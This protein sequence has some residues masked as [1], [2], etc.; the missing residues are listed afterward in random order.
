[1]VRLTSYSVLLQVAVALVALGI[2]ALSSPSASAASVGSDPEELTRVGNVL[3]FSAQGAGGRELWKSDGTDAGTVRVKDIR[4]GSGSSNP[5]ALTD[6]DGTLF[7]MAFDGTDG[8]LWASDGTEAGTK[9]VKNVIGSEFTAVGDKLFFAIANELWSSDGTGAGTAAIRTFGGDKYIGELE[10]VGDRLFV[11]VLENTTD[12]LWVSDGSAEGTRLVEKVDHVEQATGI[13]TMTAV[14]DRLFFLRETE[15][16]FDCGCTFP[17]DLWTSDGTS[18]G[19]H[20]V[21]DLRTGHDDVQNLVGAKGILYLQEGFNNLWR[22]DGTKAGTTK[23]K[24]FDLLDPAYPMTNVAGKV[25]LVADGAL[26]KSNGT[27]NGTKLVD[28]VLPFQQRRCGPFGPCHLIFH[29][30]DPV[31]S[32]GVL[33]FPSATGGDGVELWR[34]D[35]TAQGTYEVKDIQSG[36][37]GS[38]PADL[39]RVGDRVFFSANDGTHGRELWLTDGTEQGTML[40]RDI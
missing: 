1:M 22:S 5:T 16:G 31:A 40:V 6:V 38:R 35:G 25:F 39:T 7:F 21:K 15:F 27:A 20:R 3:F 29:N 34:S 13:W 12:Q 4:P 36:M 17:S 11:A 33:Y 28:D 26:W 2:G 37:D 30:Y 8:G 24:R 23:V 10:A 9:L 19:T 14:G 18:D 32:H